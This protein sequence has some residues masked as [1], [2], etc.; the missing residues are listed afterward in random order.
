MKIK[1]KGELIFSIAVSVCFWILVIMLMIESVNIGS[2]M[3]AGCCIWA[4]IVMVLPTMRVITMDKQGCT[5]SWLKFKKIHKWE[6]LE[7][8]REDTWSS[9]RVAL[10]GIVFSRKAVGKNGKVYSPEK[11]YRSLNYLNCFYVI[12]ENEFDTKI[13]DW[14]EKRGRKIKGRKNEEQFLKQLEEWGVKVEKGEELKKQEQYNAM[15]KA[16]K[17]MRE[18]QEKRVKEDLS[19]NKK[20]NKQKMNK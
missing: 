6:E 9:G 7:I 4:T 12:F 8:I 17:K 5:V 13:Y 18:E 20:K 15:V 14:L 1:T 3:L 16:R 19:R 2:I 11:I 10:K